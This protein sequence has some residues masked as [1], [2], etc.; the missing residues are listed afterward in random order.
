MGR[1]VT[2]DTPTTL[3]GGAAPSAAG[4]TPLNAANATFDLAGNTVTANLSAVT[5]LALI[6]AALQTQIAAIGGIFAGATFA[7]DTDR[8]LLTLTG[9]DDISPPYFGTAATGTDISA[10]LGMAM[11][12]NPIYARGLD[13]ETVVESAGEIL[14]LAASGP[15]VAIMLAGDAPDTAGTPPVNTRRTLGAWANAGDFMFGLR[16]SSALALTAN[17]TTSE[18]AVAFSANQGKTLALTVPTALIPT[19]AGWRCYRLRT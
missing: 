7:Y 9:V 2:S 3:R 16:D 13:A 8:F 18:L 14:A 5:T 4:A 6:A 17:E 1:W 15:P 19:L 12:D 10:A 11:A